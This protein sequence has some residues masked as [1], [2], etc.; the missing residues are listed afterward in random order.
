MTEG[1]GVV[2]SRC[3]NHARSA[4]VRISTKEGRKTSEIRR[5]EKVQV[6]AKCEN[7]IREAARTTQG[8]K[9]E[10]TFKKRPNEPYEKILTFSETGEI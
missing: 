2:A 5:K 6:T 4:T 3:N 10:K 9:V 7:N 8:K 1:P